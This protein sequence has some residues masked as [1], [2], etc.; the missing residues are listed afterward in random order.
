V[1]REEG[2]LSFLTKFVRFT[3]RTLWNKYHRSAPRKYLPKTGEVQTYNDVIVEEKRLGDDFILGLSDRPTYEGQYVEYVRKYVKRGDIVVVIGGYHGVSTV[4]AANRVGNAGSVTTFEATEKGARRVK[5]T[6]R[7]NDVDDWVRVEPATVGPVHSLK[8]GD[9]GSNRV[10]PENLPSC[11][12]LAIDCDGCELE[13]LKRLDIE[14]RLIIV[15]HHG[16]SPGDTGLE[17]EYQRENLETILT[18]TGYTIVDECSRSRTHGGFEDRI[19][20]FVAKRTD[21][22]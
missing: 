20:W 21:L 16:G 12:V 14:P 5:R 15:E 18:A 2:P 4:A 7:L 6:V 1:L 17:F 13:V 11:D 19:G 22:Q 9:S 3:K 10:P 8:N